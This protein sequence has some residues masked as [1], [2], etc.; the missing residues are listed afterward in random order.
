MSGKCSRVVDKEDEREEA[1]ILVERP[2]RIFHDLEQGDDF[3]GGWQL[4]PGNDARVVNFT[5]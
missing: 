3:R 1:K 5:N 2:M 4:R